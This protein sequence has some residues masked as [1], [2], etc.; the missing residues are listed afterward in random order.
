MAP[1]KTHELRIDITP[2][3]LPGDGFAAHVNNARY[4][5]FINQTF[6][7]WYRRMGLRDAHSEFA[8]FMAHVSYDFLR[9]VH[10]PGTILCKVALVKAGRTSIE[11]TIEIWDVSQAPVLAG[12]GKAVHVGVHRPTSKPTPWPAEVLALCW[13]QEEVLLQP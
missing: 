3:D 10:Y 1:H 8:I 9:E 7:G 12:R 13:D 5:A 2:E 11:H 4:F 6:Q